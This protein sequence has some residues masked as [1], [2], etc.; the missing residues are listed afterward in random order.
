MHSL[1]LPGLDETMTMPEVNPRTGPWRITF[2]TNPDLCNLHCV[3]CEEN[4]PYNKITKN[5][6]TEKRLMKITLIERVLAD[7][8]SSGLKE[9]IPSTMG[10]PLLYPDFEKLLKLVRSYNLKLN[11]TTNGTFPRL[12]AKKWAERI[13]PIASDVKISINGATRRTAETIM[14]GISF[15]AQLANI[16]TW[17]KVRDQLRNSGANQPTIT[18]QVTFM[19]QNLAELKDLLL[20]AIKLGVD[21]FKGHHLWITWPELEPVSLRRDSASIS[22]WNTVVQD[23]HRIARENA[24]PNGRKIILD[25]IHELSLNGNNAMPPHWICPFL[26][27]EAWIA[28]DG[29]FN[30]CCAPDAQRRTLGDFGNVNEVN[31]MTLWQS[32]AYQHLIQKWGTYPV[33]A[34]C[35]MRRPI[36]TLKVC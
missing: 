5:F 31:F 8:S 19:E 29:T 18:F 14:T 25:N 21:R 23:L 1:T 15:E 4:S 24:L 20:L 33:C 16:T 35:N 12:G 22:Q 27:H 13:L 7:A 17:L 6:S 32:P 9:I 36:D 34:A 30:V 28:W 3:M 2:D 26:G 10:E 11:L